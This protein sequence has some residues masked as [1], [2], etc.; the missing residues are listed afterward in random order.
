MFTIQDGRK[1]VLSL[2]KDFQREVREMLLLT[3]LCYVVQTTI[4][5]FLHL[6]SICCIY[7]ICLIHTIIEMFN[8]WNFLSL[9]YLIFQ[10]GDLRKDV[11]CCLEDI[12]LKDVKRQL[13]STVLLYSL[14]WITGLPVTSLYSSLFLSQLCIYFF[15]FPY[16]FFFTKD[17]FPARCHLCGCCSNC[18]ALVRIFW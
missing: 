12:T 3:C 11:K 4:L 7:G 2:V 15:L 8:F 6:F 17:L 5:D 18:K 9:W 1:D 10:K 14:G 16:S 13:S